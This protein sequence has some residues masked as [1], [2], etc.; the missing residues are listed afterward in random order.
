[1]PDLPPRRRR[2]P[3]PSWTRPVTDR[4]T[5][6]IKILVIADTLIFLFYVMVREIRPLIE[7]HLALGPGMLRGELWQPLTALF[8]H[9]DALGFIFN[10]IGLWF[11]GAFIE[12]TR[13]TRS[14][15]QIFFAAG[16]LGF[17]AM[18]L[19]G[20]VAK[21]Y[22]LG[23]GCSYAVLALFVA[24]GKMYDRTPAQ[25]LGG[26]TLQARYLA[27]ILVGWALVADLMRGNWPGLAASLVATAVGFVLAGGGP[28]DLLSLLRT[29]WLRRRY[30][31]LDGGQSL[32]R[33]GGRAGQSGGK[34][35]GKNAG[36]G[37]KGRYW[38]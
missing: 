26:L 27:M 37:V 21:S 14:F 36:K 1:M 22:G 30:R 25:V 6:A 23:D 4:L 17:V 9:L 2:P 20:R 5:P 28:R 31:V 18:A 13:G 34:A 12:R 7:A 32:G 35:G 15:L 10:M 19:V 3:A 29:R 11:V 24:F 16:V 33:Q 38:N 8:V